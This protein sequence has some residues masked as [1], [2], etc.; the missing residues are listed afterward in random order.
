MV[1]TSPEPR[2]PPPPRGKTLPNPL[3]M[4][5]SQVD[6]T[7]SSRV[8]KAHTLPCNRGRTASA[9]ELNNAINNNNLGS[10]TRT[11]TPQSVSILS[12]H[13]SDDND[14]YCFDN[15]ALELNDDI[16]LSLSP[17][18]ED[19]VFDEID[20]NS[21]S[22]NANVV[23]N[24]MND[25]PE[26]L[27]LAYRD[28]K[29]VPVG[30]MP[31]SSSW[32]DGFLHCLKPVMSSFMGKGKPSSS[33][34]DAA[35]DWEIPFEGIS[36]LQWL[37][38]GA[39]GAVF[40]GRFNTELVA[41]KKVKDLV[42]T[43]IH[44]LRKLNHP[45]IVQFRG[46]CTQAPVFCVVMEYCPYGPLFN[47]L[48]EGSERVPPVKLVEWTK[49][50]ASGVKYLH[51]HKIIHRDLKSPNVLIS[52]NAEILK[53]SDF[54]TSRTWGEQS[55][56]MSF[57][58]TVAWMAPEVIR[59]EPCNEKVDIWSYGVLL[60][61]LLTCEVP[62]RNVD[63]SAIIW[64]VGSNSL[65]LPIPKTCPDGYKLLMKQ[66]WS[67]KSRNRPSFKHILM[68][69]EIAAVEVLS[70]QP[71]DYFKTQQSWKQEVWEHNEK[72]KGE[73]NSICDQTLL[74]KQRKQELKHA[75]DVKELYEKKLDK[76][77]DL[78]MELNAW[79]L[80][81]EEEE[82]NLQRKKKQLNSVQA[83]K[84][85]YKKKLKPLVISKAQERFQ[86]KSLK[87]APSSE[88]RSTS[89]ESPFKLPLP[90][91]SQP[92][93]PLGAAAAA[94]AGSTSMQYNQRQ[95]PQVRVN[96][97]SSYYHQG[98]AAASS[99]PSSPPPTS[100]LLRTEP[101]SS[102]TA[103][104]VTRSRVPPPLPLTLPPSMN[105]RQQI[106]ESEDELR[107]PR[108]PNLMV[109]SP[110]TA[111]FTTQETQTS[112]KSEPYH[113]SAEKLEVRKNKHRRAS[114]YSSNAPL[115][116]RLSPM[117]ERRIS[118]GS[119]HR[120]ASQNGSVAD[121]EEMVDG[122]TPFPM[123]LFFRHQD[124]T[125]SMNGHLTATSPEDLTAG[126]RR[127]STSS[128]CS[129]DEV[130]QIVDDDPDNDI[131]ETLDRKVSEVINRSRLNSNSQCGS[132]TNNADIYGPLSFSY[133]RERRNSPAAARRLSPGVISG[134]VRFGDDEDE[135]AVKVGGNLTDDSSAD[136]NDDRVQW[137]N[138]DDEEQ[139]IPETTLNNA[140][141]IKRKSI[142][143][144]PIRKMSGRQSSMSMYSVTTVSSEE[145]TNSTGAPGVAISQIPQTSVE[146]SVQP[147][148]PAINNEG[149][150]D[151]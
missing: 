30:G 79:K 91:C 146:K 149:S 141:T 82:R 113:P 38:S 60:W 63:S 68:H 118:S 81:L 93:S 52:R 48:R 13:Q 67:A 71:D 88:G 65:Q 126:I 114:S 14:G 41:V 144:K 45:N 62:Y 22:K 148:S 69:L 36:D 70:Y 120:R 116:P 135:E 99:D 83:S 107:V 111:T 5:Q 2:T 23:S 18:P 29:S 138:D 98:A 92:Q 133:N 139:K 132:N 31:R 11:R 77:N 39:Q 21:S 142:S 54:G 89:P 64:G 97:L 143:R 145:G 34:S 128:S 137:S 4:R 74:I 134:L 85:H 61:E 87:Y 119:P 57:A 43:N 50:I 75:L 117:R 47:Y 20:L 102:S 100:G 130:C 26:G 104:T 80:Q 35:D 46:V 33:Q 6:L 103:L 122:Q 17:E 10:M 125:T 109:T 24:S 37:G 66:C 44:H 19:E 32:Y 147:L 9:I 127:H 8:Q 136:D 86:K 105:D 123:Q 115:S 3:L 140:F 95:Q 73:D 78:F 16:H 58:G 1:L 53:I 112:L 25:I 90:F 84:V 131:L 150:I 101:S 49:Q 40:V 56:C 7:V 51:D 28:A 59:N 55:T 129:S 76:V 106:D 27:K 110:T 108:S 94:S 12:L 96:P 15:S 124:S 121:V 72:V 151:L 42:D